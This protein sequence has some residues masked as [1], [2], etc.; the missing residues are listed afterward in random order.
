M[1]IYENM[2]WHY[3]IEVI[4]TCL[5]S[6]KLSIIYKNIFLGI[7]QYQFCGNVAQIEIYRFENKNDNL[8][9]QRVNWIVY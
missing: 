2:N 6:H 7:Y 1:S 5:K 8:V 4:M 9:K 3:C